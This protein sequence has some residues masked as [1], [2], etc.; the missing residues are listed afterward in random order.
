MCPSRGE[1]CDYKIGEALAKAKEELPHGEYVAACEELGYS[2]KDAHRLRSWYEACKSADSAAFDPTAAEQKL[3]RHAR[4]EFCRAEQEV[5]TAV[6]DWLSR[7]KLASHQKRHILKDCRWSSIEVDVQPPD[8][9]FSY[10]PISF[11]HP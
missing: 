1:Y 10:L 11:R 6:L 3:S 8:L 5:Q 4:E 7:V 9:V 2:Q